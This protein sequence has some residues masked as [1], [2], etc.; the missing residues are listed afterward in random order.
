M[1]TVLAVLFSL[2][3][4]DGFFR[5]RTLNDDWTAP[6]SGKGPVR[7]AGWLFSVLWIALALIS[8]FVGYR[9]EW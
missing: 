7:R 6:T 1:F 4:L 5:K 2:F 9:F 3:A 8:L